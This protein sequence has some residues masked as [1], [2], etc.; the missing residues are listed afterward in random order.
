VKGGNFDTPQLESYLRDFHTWEPEA[1]DARLMSLAGVAP[2]ELGPPR[3]T[4]INQWLDKQMK[5]YISKDLGSPTDPLLQ[6]EKEYPN[7]HLP[8]GEVGEAQ[9]G[10]DE[11]MSNAAWGRQGRLGKYQV[12][13]DRLNT[14]EALSGGAPMT[15]WGWNADMALVSSSPARF[16]RTL[17]GRNEAVPAWLD[18]APPET[19]IWGMHPQVAASA[20]DPLGIGHIRDYLDAA[21]QAHEL[22]ADEGANALN[23]MVPPIQR[24]PRM[25]RALALHQAGLTLDPQSLGRLSVADAVRKTAQ[26]NEHLATAG[27]AGDPDL[28]RGI[29]QV[30]KEYPDSGHRW[31]ELGHQTPTSELPPGYTMFEHPNWQERNIHRYGVKHTESGAVAGAEGDTPEN[32]IGQAWA[33]R[34]HDD[35][36]AGLNAEGNAMGHCVGGY[37]DDVASRGTK[38]FSLRDAAGAPHVTV[39]VAPSRQYA[40]T[41]MEDFDEN[42]RIAA[43]RKMLTTPAE[44]GQ[45]T[46]ELNQAIDDGDVTDLLTNS[47]W[48]QRLPVD[49]STVGDIVQIKGKQNAAPVDKYLPMVQDFVKNH[50]PWGRVG[51]LQNTGLSFIDK[52][53]PLTTGMNSFAYKL[54]PGYYTQDDLI[55]A[56]SEQGV[57]PETARDSA[58]NYWQGSWKPHPA[59]YAQGGSVQAPRF[60]RHFKG[61][62]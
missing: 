23:R 31:V 46:R 25:N 5:N 8:E 36:A 28:A 54:D 55:K 26:W 32:V 50:G 18:K 58:A 61:A 16:S 21:T 19:K 38:I 6:V 34:N 39:E 3:E 40:S 14:H 22:T 24:E 35:L 20:G 12:A 44:R 2:G 1:P 60:A 4:M 47:A 43:I 33:M 13:A 49:K 10:L 7:L 45:F 59:N 57:S 29:K 42:D 11:L 27:V 9:A 53:H 15:P 41:G 48:S 51:D 56:M 37:C 62:R 30:V 17:A 52:D